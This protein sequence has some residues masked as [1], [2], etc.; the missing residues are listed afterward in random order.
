MPAI[1]FVLNE[2][3][4]PAQSGS[5]GGFGGGSRS[6]SGAEIAFLTAA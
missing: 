2:P 4:A 5:G 3:R 1:Y 6:A